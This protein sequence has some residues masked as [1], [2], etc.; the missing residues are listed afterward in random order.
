MQDP[1]NYDNLKKSAFRANQLVNAEHEMWA[2]QNMSLWPG[3]YNTE[4]A[5]DC[6][7][8]L[9][10]YHAR[11]QPFDNVSYITD[12]IVNDRIRKNHM[13][14][15]DEI[16]PWAGTASNA[17]NIDFNPGNYINFQGLRRPR[18]VE[19]ID[20]WQVTELDEDDLSENRKFI[21]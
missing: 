8:E 19:Q 5:G 11:P 7:K 13:E 16:K 15:V 18:G 21:F 2:D 10:Q 17:G 6:T 1:N 12:Q 3:H 20:P 4:N 14:W 9:V